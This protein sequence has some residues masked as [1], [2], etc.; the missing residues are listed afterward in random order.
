MLRG[1]DEIDGQGVY[2]RNLCDALLD[3]DR[4]NQYVLFYRSA[5]QAGRYAD[6]PNVVERVIRGPKLL[7]DQVAIPIA[8][9]RA[10]VDVLFHHKFSIPLFASCATVVQQRAAEYWKF[11]DWYG[12]VDR[13]YST[14]AIPIYC[15]RAT[16]VLTNSD[17]LADDLTRYAGVPRDKITT[18]LA[19]ADARFAP[20]TDQAEIDRV[21]ARYA[22]PEQPFFLMVAKG[23]PSVGYTGKV[24]YPR[25]NV[26][27]TLLAYDRVQRSTT[28][29]PPLVVAGPGITDHP[30]FADI[31]EPIDTAAVSFPGFVDHADIPAVYSMARALIFPSYSESFG[32][33]LV[34]A[35]ACGC[36]VISS[37]TGACPEVVGDA[38]I[39][40]DPDDL[41]GL[42]AA[43]RSL[44]TDPGLAADLRSRGLRRAKDFS[45]ERS[46]RRLLQVLEET[47]RTPASS[48]SSRS[49]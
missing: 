31:V 37:T 29:C 32:I 35:M 42:A 12:P 1:I 13:F 49:R 17:T 47:A 39:L 33:P 20:V 28:D 27:G 26:V 8:A 10:G 16:R 4:I 2:I 22:L 45:W 40:V 3:L 5:G 15:R 34:E 46:A 24:F 43:I 30:N 11:R 7:W 41:G 23:Y 48:S 21:R 18:V 19:A 36:P 25:K 38:G 14:R 44:V 9:A 6:R